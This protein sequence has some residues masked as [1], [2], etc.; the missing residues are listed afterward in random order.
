MK[1]AVFEAEDR[2]RAAFES[3][4]A[5]HNVVFVPEPL[6]PGMIQHADAD[7]IS[8][9]IYSE[10][11]QDVIDRFPDLKLIA[12]RST[13]FEHI[14]A[15]RCKE[16]GIAICNVPI[17]GANT[18]AEHVFALLLSISHRMSEAVARAQRGHFSPFGLQGFDIAGKTF[19]IIG[20]GSIG[21]HVIR[22]A[23][24][25][26]MNVIAFD[27]HQDEKLASELGFSYVTL[28]ELLAQS[29]VVSL[30]VP[31]MPSTH[32][33]ICTESIAKMKTGAV[34]INVSRGDLI[35][36]GALIQALTTGKISAAGLDVLPDE[37]MIREEARLI[38]TIFGNEG[39][40]R[41]LVANHILLRLRN[42]VVTPHS[43][44]NT[45]EAVDRIV[46]TTADNIAAFLAGTPKNLVALKEKKKEK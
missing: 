6:K 13:G 30:H 7:I 44:F 16:R 36:T 9:F 34:I 31:S 40:L 33:L 37:P 23:K 4:R 11:G 45:K 5:K 35:E 8:T 38:N 29:D 41:T 39:E 26:A 20:T 19:G 27:V 10:M 42:V 1:I 28:D 12:T 17:Y 24:G 14:D 15:V 22:I 43:A 32:H 2:E 25:F 21:R 46:N 3:L 18:V